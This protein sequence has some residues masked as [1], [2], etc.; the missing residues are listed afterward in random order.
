MI[1]VEEFRG[2]LKGAQALDIVDNVLLPQPAI[3]LPPEKAQLI[4]SSLAIA[5][6]VDVREVNIIPM[7]SAHLGF[8]LVEKRR[9]DGPVLHRYRPYGA[10]SDFDVAV[11][12]PPIS[13]SSGMS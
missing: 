13:T 4:A 10:D 9:R 5:Y 1:T 6:G 11:I 3:H 7:G 2:V 8:S 12:C